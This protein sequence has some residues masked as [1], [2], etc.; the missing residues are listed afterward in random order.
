MSTTAG[1]GRLTVIVLALT[2][3]ALVFGSAAAG[4]GDVA[5]EIHDVGPVEVHVDETVTVTYTA[6]G[7][8]I[9]DD[10]VELVFEH[11]RGEEVRVGGE[12]GEEVSQE[13]DLDPGLAPGPYDLR[14]EVGGQTAERAEAVEVLP[15]VDP[16]AAA[17]GTTASSTDDVVAEYEV[18]AGDLAEVAVSLDG[19]EEAYVLV[20]GD[21]SVGGS[22]QSDAPLDVLHVDGSATFVVNTRLVGTD[23]PSEE[24]YIPVDGEVTSY[25][26][27]LGADAEPAGVFE[28]LH[29]ETEGYGNAGDTL[30]EFRS[31]VGVGAQD[32]PLQ[33]SDVSLV[34]AGGDSLVVTD[35]GFPDARFPLDRANLRLTEPELGDVTTYRLPTANA[36]D[37]AFALDPD[38]IDDLE[39]GDV[40]WLLEEAQ[41]VGTL[42]AGDRLLV[43][44]EATGLYGALLDSVDGNRVAD[45]EAAL[46]DPAEFGELV[47]RPE[48]IEFE[49]VHA[50]A[51][52]NVERTAVNLFESPSNEVT[53]LTG[54]PLAEEPTETDRLYLLVDTRGPEPFDPGLE[55]GEEYELRVSYVPPEHEPYQFGSPSLSTLP[56]PF[57]PRTP[58]DG[59]GPYPYFDVDD[60][61]ETRSSS[62]AVEEPVVEYDRLVDGEV[63]LGATSNATLPGTTNL[64]PG[65]GLPIQV[66]I[67]VRDDPTTVEVEG[68]DVD[69]EGRFSVETDLSMLEP[70]EEV[71]VAFHAFQKR[72]D[73]RPA[74]VVEPDDVGG[75]FNVTEMRARSGVD[76]EEPFVQSTMRVTNTGLLADNGT[77]ELR[78]DGEPVANESLE[79][80]PGE[81]T[82]PNFTDVL[83]DL[84]PGEYVLELLTEDDRDGLLLVVDEVETVHEVTA[85]TAE[86]RA[87]EPDRLEFETTVRNT[88]TIHGTGSVELLV[89]DE[90]VGQRRATLPVGGEAS[91]EF[92]RDLAGLGP[93]NYTL[94][95][96]TPDDEASANVTLEAPSSTLEIVDA[97][98]ETSVEQGETIT[99][100]F[101]VENTGNVPGE[102]TVT[103][104]LDGSVVGDWPVELDAGE[105]GTVGEELPV[106][107]PPGEYTLRVETPDD[108]RTF[109]FVVRGPAD[110]GDEDDGDED[111]NDG[112][113]GD[114]D[115]TGGAG[116][117]LGFGVR[118]DAVVGGTAVVAGIHVLGHWV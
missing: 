46:V 109:T 111:E 113:D 39:P 10:D 105:N 29:F 58:G 80:A 108:E 33:P 15:V 117:F 67:D 68:V 23:R 1:S 115:G 25:A 82:Q 91:F 102:G 20:G 100:G 92:E 49:L 50:N 32:R 64:P 83:D 28:G 4:A 79:L 35:D 88:G 65:D 66:V 81:T 95:V 42:A 71:D 11:P 118:T 22:S 27:D 44:V 84:E 103:M 55:D 31:E 54:P 26:H 94:T 78:I 93:G 5:V 104:T 63:L 87:D 9:T 41:E 52:P 45:G 101:V 56:P 36:D 43:E 6:E 8:G 97:D 16:D 61:G 3:T 34:V 40:E 112:T 72:L 60:P 114:G 74:R 57:E 70:G 30:A 116:G 17:F 99:P 73:D 86:P 24:V 19:L 47:E 38:E 89:D 77:V 107:Q 62:F 69:E 18:V 75:R 90:V 85:L 110:D 48:G 51:P 12:R 2:A 106:T 96:R 76:G 98:V 37:R 7:E 59:P 21:R 13:V 53:F 14:V